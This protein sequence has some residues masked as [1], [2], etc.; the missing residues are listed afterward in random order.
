M[1][2]DIKTKVLRRQKRVLCFENKPSKQSKVQLGSEQLSFDSELVELKR[3]LQAEQ[4][5]NL[6]DTIGEVYRNRFIDTARELYEQLERQIEKRVESE[7]LRKAHLLAESLK[8]L[9][10]CVREVGYNGSCMNVMRKNILATQSDLLKGNNM[11]T[12]CVHQNVILQRTLSLCEIENQLLPR[13]PVAENHQ[14]T[15]GRGLRQRSR[16]TASVKRYVERRTSLDEERLEAMVLF[17]CEVTEL[18]HEYSQRIKEQLR[19]SYQEIKERVE[20]HIA[21]LNPERLNELLNSKELPW[22]FLQTSP[23]LKLEAQY[24]EADVIRSQLQEEFFPITDLDVQAELIYVLSL[25][26][27]QLLS[28]R[29]CIDKRP[30]LVTRALCRVGAWVR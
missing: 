7:S 13:S 21:N 28:L 9:R 4:F 11:A 15:Q 10:R 2:G 8:L 5:V 29:R 18:H 16:S 14:E 24:L 20:R 25:Y 1:D 19:R 12:M 23:K 26:C 30:S 27:E 3:T 17:Q 6:V 22:S